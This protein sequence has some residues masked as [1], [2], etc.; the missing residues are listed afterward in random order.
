MVGE[1]QKKESTSDA[2][3]DFADDFHGKYAAFEA[4]LSAKQT[5]ADS[6]E[7]ETMRQIWLEQISKVKGERRI[8]LR[9]VA[10]RVASPLVSR[11]PPENFVLVE[12]AMYSKTD[13]LLNT[14]SLMF[15]DDRLESDTIESSE[16]SFVSDIQLPVTF[17]RAS[18]VLGYSNTQNKWLHAFLGTAVL[19]EYRA[20]DESQCPLQKYTPQELEQR[21]RPPILDTGLLDVLALE[22]QGELDEESWEYHVVLL[23]ADYALDMLLDYAAKREHFLKLGPRF[24]EHCHC[25]FHSVLDRQA[26]VSSRFTGAQMLLQTPWSVVLDV[27]PHGDVLEGTRGMRSSKIALNRVTFDSRCIVCA[28]DAIMLEPVSPEQMHT[29]YA[30]AG[31]VMPSL[32][33]SYVEPPVTFGFDALREEKIDMYYPVPVCV[34]HASNKALTLASMAG[35]F[36]TEVEFEYSPRND[37]YGT[38]SREYMDNLAHLESAYPDSSDVTMRVSPNLRRRLLALSSGM[39]N[40]LEAI[41]CSDKKIIP[42]E[43]VPWLNM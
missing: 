5:L 12:R 21:Y 41:A 42:L 43:T 15:L 36:S 30:Q 17:K 27:Q 34:E 22:A 4:Y 40:I 2:V 14:S 35:I 7:S 25:G 28:D 23:A 26:I 3:K 29:T 31:A 33:H 9:Q 16:S 39:H 24:P 19:S 38:L 20:S 13:A 11:I 8:L 1:E 18:V 10:S 6:Q 32:L 37:W